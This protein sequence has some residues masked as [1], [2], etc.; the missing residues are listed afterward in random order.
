MGLFSFLLLLGWSNDGDGKFCAVDN[1]VFTPCSFDFRDKCS[2]HFLPVFN[3][4]VEHVN[5]L[6]CPVNDLFLSSFL[7][8]FIVLFSLFI[9]ICGFFFFFF[10]SSK[11]SLFIH[12]N[13]SI[14][15]KPGH[16]SLRGIFWLN[17]RRIKS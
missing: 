5:V 14:I 17:I 9:G 10:L 4:S 2:V 6:L 12:E 7:K 13:S 11:F 8:I 16:Y 15:Y 1:T 3:Y